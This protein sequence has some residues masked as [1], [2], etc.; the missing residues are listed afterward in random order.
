MFTINRADE[1]ALRK[2]LRLERNMTEKEI[3]GLGSAYFWQR[4]R[5]DFRPEEEQL[6]LFERT[7]RVSAR[8]LV[9]VFGA[10]IELSLEC[11]IYSQMSG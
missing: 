2:H 9:L 10:N 3:L 4:C 11:S 7:V 8:I 6:C 5:R 1:L